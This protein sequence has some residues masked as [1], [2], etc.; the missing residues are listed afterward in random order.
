MISS[1]DLEKAFLSINNYYHAGF[2]FHDRAGYCRNGFPE[3]RNAWSKVKNR[4][5]T[6]SLILDISKESDK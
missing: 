3:A 2:D 5:L 6:E 1:S 4:T